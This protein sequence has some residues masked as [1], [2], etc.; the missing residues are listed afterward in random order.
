[1]PYTFGPIIVKRFIT[2]TALYEGNNSSPPWGQGKKSGG[3]R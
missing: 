2:K 3:L 1:M